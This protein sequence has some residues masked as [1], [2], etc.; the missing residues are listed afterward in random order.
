MKAHW[1][2]SSP[3][4]L[5]GKD[6][7]AGGTWMGISTNGRLSALTNY[8]NPADMKEHMKSRGKL[9]YSYLDGDMS[10]EVCAE[11]LS[12]SV[13]EYNGYNL[14]FGDVDN[15]YWYSNKSDKMQHLDAGLYGLSNHLLDTPWPKVTRGKKLFADAI[16]EDFS[17]D[18]LFAVLKDDVKADDV[19]LPQTGVSLELER[20]LSPIFIKSP[21]YG[22][23]SSTVITV[24]YDNHAT[25]AER[26]YNCNPV[27]LDSKFEFQIT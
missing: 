10:P 1:R 4:I 8:R 5:A 24:N 18:D 17:T 26:T 2:G 12:E 15:L 11:I 16:S 20:I 21:E 19:D 3:D 25:F 22:T 23:R 27:W 9:V 13:S 14:L 6:M 7:H